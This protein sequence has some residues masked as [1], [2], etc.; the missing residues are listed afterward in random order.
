MTDK[1]IREM[2]QEEQIRQLEW[3]DQH[4]FSYSY[5]WYLLKENKQLKERINKAI[6]Y[7]ENGDL[8]YLASKCSII[9]KD[10]IEIVAICDRL[11]NLLEILK[12]E[13]N[14]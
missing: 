14:E 5:A 1:E 10:N 4:E 2:T 12:G 6:E 13:E 3:S 8:L 11:E 9:Y 7:I